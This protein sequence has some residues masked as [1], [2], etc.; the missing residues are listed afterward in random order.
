GTRPPPR[1]APPAESA[2]GG[3]PTP[4]ENSN[5]V[6]VGPRAGLRGVEGAP[7]APRGEGHGGRMGPGQ[8]L[9]APRGPGGP[10]QTTQ[11]RPCVVYQP[12]SDELAR[13]RLENMRSFYTTDRHRLFGKE[14]NR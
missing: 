10:F 5:L 2:R 12:V 13:R 3:P 4:G 6:P 11:T 9:G 14:I 1:S 8:G 7:L